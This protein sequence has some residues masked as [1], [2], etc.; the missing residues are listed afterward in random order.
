VSDGTIAAV[1][2]T[3]DRVNQQRN[4]LM[5]KI[6]T[7]LLDEAGVQNA[8]APLHSETPGMMVDRLSILALKI[9]HTAEEAQRQTA[10]P[11]HRAWNLERLQVL[12]QQRA[13]L[14]ACLDALWAQVLAGERRFRL[15]RQMK[16]YNDPEL[17]PAVYSR[18]SASKTAAPS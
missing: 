8:A 12:Q 5:E 1:K 11:A 17:N 3:I 7:A 6:D 2:H 9:Y 15:Y 10:S 13:D 18:K 4:D 14:A 16:M